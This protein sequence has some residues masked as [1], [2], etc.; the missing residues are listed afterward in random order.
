VKETEG[1]T[2]KIAKAADGRVK[3]EHRDHNARSVNRERIVF[4]LAIKLLADSLFHACPI[5]NVRL[6]IK[7]PD[8]GDTLSM[9]SPSPV[10]V[11]LRLQRA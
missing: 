11:R 6:T 8:S 7:R 9:R 3:S 1:F 2:R 4:C 10:T 5:G